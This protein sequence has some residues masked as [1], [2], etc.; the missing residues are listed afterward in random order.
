MHEINEIKDVVSGPV[1]R[2]LFT[3]APATGDHYSAGRPMLVLLQS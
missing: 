1:L 3:K 2:G